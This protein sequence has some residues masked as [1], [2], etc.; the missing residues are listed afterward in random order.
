[1][2]VAGIDPGKDGGVAIR[3]PNGSWVA[4][5]IPLVGK[6]IGVAQIADEL[7]SLNVTRVVIE[8]QQSM[9]KQGLVS[10]FTIGRNYGMLLGMLAAR[11][12]PFVEITAQQWKGRILKGTKKDK[13]AAIS[14]ANRIAPSVDLTP[15]K[16][17]TPHDGMADAICMAEY[18]LTLE[19]NQ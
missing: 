1:M 13:P 10:T 8:R 5:P 6:D 17:T 16:R 3:C 19:G 14:Y 11:Q 15:G 18:A 2:R 12:I 7:C 9:P 4:F